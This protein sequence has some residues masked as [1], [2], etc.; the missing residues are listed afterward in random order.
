ML[1]KWVKPSPEEKPKF[2]P[3]PEGIALEEGGGPCVEQALPPRKCLN[4][5]GW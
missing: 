2:A 5:R 3:L 1:A 4:Y